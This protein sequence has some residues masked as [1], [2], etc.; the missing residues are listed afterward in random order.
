MR[1][2]LDVLH[3]AKDASLSFQHVGRR[4]LAGELPGIGQRSGNQSTFTPAEILGILAEMFLGNGLSPIDTIAHLDRIEIYLHDVFLGPQK[5]D[6]HGE[7]CLKTLTHPRTAWPEKHVLCCLLCDGR[8]AQL[9]F[10][11]MLSVTLGGMLDGLIVEPMMLQEPCILTG[12][13]GNW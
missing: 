10:L 4:R 2:F 11:R 6:K 9:T 5:L 7:I 12:H 3:L 1:E 8:G 13:D